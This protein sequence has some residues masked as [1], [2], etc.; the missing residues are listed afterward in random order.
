MELKR[1]KFDVCAEVSEVCR[2]VAPLIAARAH[3]LVA[4]ESPAPALVFA[5]RQRIRQI[6]LNLVSNAI[7]FTPDGGIIRITIGTDADDPSLV[8]V[9]IQDSGI[10]IKP[11]DFPKLFEKFRQLDAAHNRR[12]EGTGLGL[13]LTKQLVE[14]NGGAITVISDP[15]HGST[16][17]FTVPTAGVQSHPVT[18]PPSLAV[19]AD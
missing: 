19:P 7:K 9:A 14:L 2:S 15:G 6:I 16:F 18:L 13:A 4:D 12:Y 11:D 3:T 17:A 1:A 10:G 5:D 8:R